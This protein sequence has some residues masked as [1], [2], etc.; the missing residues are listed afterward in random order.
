MNKVPYQYKE[1]H[2]GRAASE[3]GAFRW[4]W[5]RH[6]RWL[7]IV[8]CC[9]AL[10]GG[11]FFYSYR[12]LISENT[13]LSDE[14]K[15]LSQRLAPFEAIA[16]KSFPNQ[17]DR[18]RLDLLIASIQE[19]NVKYGAF[20][21]KRADEIQLRKRAAEFCTQ[22]KSKN[23]NAPAITIH[24]YY[25]ASDASRRFA[26]QLRSILRDCQWEVAVKTG[27]IMQKPLDRGLMI[28]RYSELSKNPE[29]FL[30]CVNTFMSM[31]IDL[32]VMMF[33]TPE[34]DDSRLHLIIND[35]TYLR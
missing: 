1:T 16:A 5:E 7:V 6:P 25:A 15:T 9:I 23:T 32:K 24:V 26:D 35:P 33:T 10:A 2:I 34:Q 8:G 12:C 28:G 22:Y 13:R 19:L 27:E 3:I 17:E 21:L 20:A 29:T 31:S 18:G 14:V 4:L 11:C 30:F